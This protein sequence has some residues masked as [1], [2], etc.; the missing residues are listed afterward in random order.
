MK[1]SENDTAVPVVHSSLKITDTKKSDEYELVD[2]IRMGREIRSNGWT[3]CGV[4]KVKT[5][6]ITRRE[7]ET[8]WRRDDGALL[9]QTMTEEASH[10]LTKSSSKG[11]QKT[12]VREMR[13]TGVPDHRWR[14]GEYMDEFERHLISPDGEKIINT[15]P[16]Y[17]PDEEEEWIEEVS[18]DDAD[19]VIHRLTG[20]E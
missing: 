1:H 5:V 10:Q 16:A 19:S 9:T 12:A 15:L 3:M 6:Q 20:G 11:A 4:G 18:L 17:E 7:V 13:R 2:G 8:I 14:D